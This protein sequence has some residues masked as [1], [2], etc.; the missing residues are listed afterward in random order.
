MYFNLKFFSEHSKRPNLAF[1]ISK[2]L[3]I[4]K[5]IENIPVVAKGKREGR[6][7]D[8]E[9]GVSRGKVFYILI[10]LINKRPYCIAQGAIFN[11]L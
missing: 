8:W 11:I 7:M 10:E 5:D 6:R 2:I 4:E 3:D 9:L 1:D